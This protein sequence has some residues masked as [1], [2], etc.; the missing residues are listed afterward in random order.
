MF[1]MRKYSKIIAEKGLTNNKRQR[2]R[3]RE[4]DKH[5]D[6]RKINGRGH[7]QIK[8]NSTSFVLLFQKDL[9]KIKCNEKKIKRKDW[10]LSLRLGLRFGSQFGFGWKINRKVKAALGISL[11]L[12]GYLR[13]FW[14]RSNALCIR[15]IIIEYKKMHYLNPFK[16][17]RSAQI[18]R[19]RAE[20][21]HVFGSLFSV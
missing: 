9:I 19:H 1:Q 8:T 11:C 20:P 5:C 2:L 15:S 17:D 21:T 14:R 10:R 6:P 13:A 7:K 16:S 12:I 18:T 4:R 3:E